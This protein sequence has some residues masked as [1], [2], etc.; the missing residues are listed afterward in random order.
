MC[1]WKQQGPQCQES[2]VTDSL[3]WQHKQNTLLI[4]I[5]F[6]K[7]W[8]CNLQNFKNILRKKIWGWD[9]EMKII[10]CDK[11]VNAIQWNVFFFITQPCQIV[12][13]HI[14]QN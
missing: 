11:F 8:G 1:F 4:G 2:S 10:L 3:P 12:S 5:Y 13:F 6:K 9:F 7:Y 14:W